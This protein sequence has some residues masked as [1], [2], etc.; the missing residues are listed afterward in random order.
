MHHSQY[1][2][3]KTP[4]VNVIVVIAFCDSKILYLCYLIAFTSDVVLFCCNTL[5]NCNTP[6]F[7][8]EPT[9][10]VSDVEGGKKYTF[11]VEG[12]FQL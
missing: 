7:I 9:N 11:L 4:T 6:I 12:L 3:L 1:F 10:I 8:G 5:D 2:L